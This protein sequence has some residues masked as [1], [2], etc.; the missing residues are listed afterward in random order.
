M[1][2]K[3]KVIV[4]D[5]GFFMFAAG[6]ACISNPTMHLQYTVLNMIIGNLRKI[7]VNKDDTVIIAVDFHGEDY[8]SWRKLYS[9]EYKGGRKGLPTATYEKL[10]FLLKEIDGFSNFHIITANHAEADDCMAVAC[11]YYKDK[12]IV[13]VVSDADLCQMWHYPNVK[14]FSPHRLS[15]RY[16]M[17]P[18]NFDVQKSIL[19]CK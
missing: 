3:S 4:I 18:P 6:N 1:N 7:G 13:L 8:S 10:N 14:I 9:P 17:K 15:K 11:R 5:W 2:N 12:E 16:K 19:K